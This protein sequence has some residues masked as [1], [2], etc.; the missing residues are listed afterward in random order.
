MIVLPKPLTANRDRHWRREHQGGL[1]IGSPPT[2]AINTRFEAIHGFRLPSDRPQPGAITRSLAA[3]PGGGYA[4]Y[5][6]GSA[7]RNSD[8]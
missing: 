7:D 8:S 5:Y 4:P 6:I 3:D 2:W 1:G